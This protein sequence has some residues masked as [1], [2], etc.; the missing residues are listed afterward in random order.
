MSTQT[1]EKRRFRIPSPAMLVAMVALMVALGGSALAVTAAKNSVTTKS[2][3]NGA[4]KSKKIAANGVKEKNLAAGAV[5]T[6]K[7]A[8][9]SVATGKLADGSVAAGKLADGSVVTGKLADDAVTN[10]KVADNAVE[11]AQIAQGGVGNTDLAQGA[12][13][14]GKIEPGAL[15]A[16]QFYKATTFNN[17]FPAIAATSCTTIDPTGYEDLQATDRVIMSIPDGAPAALNVRATA[18]AGDILFTACNMS[19]AAIDP[20]PLGYGVLVIRAS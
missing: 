8:D 7:L 13:S 12:V 18:E 4:V 10:A 6:G 9:R 15:V 5:T 11:T 19:G 3:K 20:D 17:D 2:I 16:Q 14:S 1:N